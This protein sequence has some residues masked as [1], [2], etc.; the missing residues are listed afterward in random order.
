MSEVISGASHILKY[1]SSGLPMTLLRFS[2]GARFY[3]LLQRFIDNFEAMQSFPYACARTGTSHQLMYLIENRSL[4][5][6][7]EVLNENGESFWDIFLTSAFVC[8]L[9]V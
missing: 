6:F 5:L 8:N 1:P 4:G 2:Q 7:L 3:Y 9:D